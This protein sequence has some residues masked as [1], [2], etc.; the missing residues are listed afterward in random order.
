MI[1]E[2]NDI[3]HPTDNTLPPAVLQ[4][5]DDTLIVFEAS[6]QGAAK[7]KDILD[8]FGSFSGL[9]IN[10]H[11]STLVPIH[12]PESTITAAVNILGCRREGFPQNYLGLP[13]SVN[14]LPVSAFT[15]L[16]HK[17][18]KYLSSWQA[19]FLNTMGRAVMVNSVLDSIL[20][21]CMC[22]L[23][24]PPSVITLMDK[25][26]RAFL[27]SGSV[28]GSASPA[29]CLVAWSNVSQPK[30][31]GGLG[32]R[33]L[34][35]QNVCLLLKL[36]HRLHSNRS[37]AWA[38]WVQGRASIVT[39]SG[40]I[41]GDHWRTL[42]SLLP[43]Y[44]AL[45]SVAIGNGKFCSFWADVWL[46][47]EALED[48]YPA[49]YSHCTLKNA[50]VHQMLQL[51][52]ERSMVPRLSNQAA[53]ELQALRA[54]L[55]SVTLTDEM[56]R[57]VSIF[58]KED[59][60]LD[61]GAIY[62]MLK[63]RGNAVDDKASFIWNNAAPP[64]VQLFMWLLLQGRIQSRVVLFKKHVVTDTTCEVCHQQDETA[65]HIIWGCRLG[66]EVWR[67]LGLSSV[68]SLDMNSLHTVSPAAQVPAQEF[69]TFMALVCWQ[70]WKARNSAVF[71]S[72]LQSVD[73][74]LLSC[75]RTAEQ[76]QARLPRKK[77]HLAATWCTIFNMARQGQG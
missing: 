61:S 10:Y 39:L 2:C 6:S 60:N 9:N 76:W 31:N 36:L 74:V 17:A 64:R 71:R 34:G 20:V 16:I 49:L 12:V 53:S 70:L 62:R 65:E 52:L 73:Q 56:D 40:D 68:I 33:D 75:E 42:R 67:K 21:Y 7:L 28:N 72:E 8:H 38:T 48:T 50:S 44:R 5:A 27:W 18:D 45:T 1:K 14:K 47:D 15:P 43:L 57:R 3:K 32:I 19:S 59:E 58:C 26:R 23:Q 51:Q 35:I 54:Q 37:S 46:Q 77:R 4:Y 41:H 30:D 63:A 22:S 25:R 55:A 69:P 11:K 24:L 66:N 13:L 29:C